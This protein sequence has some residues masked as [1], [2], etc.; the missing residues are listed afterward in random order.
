MKALY[1]TAISFFAVFCLSSFSSATVIEG[2]VLSEQGALPGAVVYAYH[3]YKSLA[4]RSHSFS[5]T[6]GEKT[7]QFHLDLQ[8][9][10]Y[11]LTAEGTTKA[12][13]YYSYH[14][15]N[16]VT[17]GSEPQWVPFFAMPDKTGKCEDG[18][19]GLGGHV[20]FQ[21]QPVANGGIS[22][23]TE[24]DEPFRGM[25][26]LTNT[27]T[28]EGE[29]WFDLEPGR[30]V[31]IARKRSSQAGI[32]PIE[33]GDLF[34]YSAANP[35]EVLPGRACEIDLFCYP[36]N[37]IEHFL[38]TDA[39]DPRGRRETTR[40][41]VSL[42]DV[43]ALNTETLPTQIPKRPA[44]I[45][46]LVTDINGS[47][48][49]GLVITAYPADE[50]KLFQMYIVR[51]KTQFMATTDKT[52]RYNLDLENGSYYLVAR[53]RVG[54]APAPQEYYGLYEGTANHNIV[55]RPGEARSDANITVGRIMP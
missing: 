17:V 54:E 52:G 20:Y 12:G 7:G 51:F 39:A 41:S 9:G 19:Q 13:K 24:T 25:G 21:G 55:V 35:V 32:G 1:I 3:D 46:G 43:P 2:I 36:R 14:G 31:L 22:V 40:R 38:S 11:Y 23:Y 18:F 26:L 48:R 5:S 29:Y 47:P 4:S 50:L 49:E 45:S 27:I 33:Q 28:T 42:Q 6:V 10:L 53:E 8:P 15:L 37:D 16:P 30:Y 34:C 44:T